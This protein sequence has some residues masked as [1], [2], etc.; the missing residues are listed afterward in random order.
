MSTDPIRPAGSAHHASEITGAAPVSRAG[1]VQQAFSVGSA[2]AASGVSPTHF[3]ALRT[4]IQ[5]GLDKKLS[6]DAI[7]NDL[8]AYETSRAFGPGAPAGI[9]DKVAEQFRTDPVLAALFND[10]FTAASTRR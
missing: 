8:V 9:K 6:R 1:D 3:A 10:L 5:D 7:L 4:R 2:S